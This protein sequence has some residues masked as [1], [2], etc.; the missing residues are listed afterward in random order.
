MKKTVTK[1]K[2]RINL[3]VSYY[4]QKIAEINRNSVLEFLKNLSLIYNIDYA[5]S[6]N[7]QFKYDKEF[8]NE[9]R[10]MESDIFYFR[11]NANT[12]INTK[13]LRTT[14]NSLFPYSLAPYYDGVEFFTQL[15]KVL[16]EYPFPKEFYRPLKYPYVEFQN[17]SKI[18]L[19]VPYEKVM[20]VIEKK[21]DFTKN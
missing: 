1:R 7:H 2:W 8:E 4:N 15:T 20:E 10:E 9:F 12:R 18:E 5:I 21:Q 3:I 14:I 11:S 13:E 19:M 17:G 16:K 6:K